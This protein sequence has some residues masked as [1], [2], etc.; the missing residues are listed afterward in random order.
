[1]FLSKTRCW[2]QQLSLGSYQNRW[3]RILSGSQPVRR[4][5]LQ[6][7]WLSCLEIDKVTSVS[8]ISLYS[9]VWVAPIAQFR[10]P[11]SSGQKCGV[12]VGVPTWPWGSHPAICDYKIDSVKLSSTGIN[13]YELGYQG[14]QNMPQMWVFY[15]PFPRLY[16]LLLSKSLYTPELLYRAVNRNVFPSCQFP[17]CYFTFPSTQASSGGWRINSHLQRC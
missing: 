13:Q 7:D 14:R 8:S 12:L 16:T 11:V 9:W 2:L 5:H 10:S 17:F 4:H 6:S 1:M 15:F 3:T